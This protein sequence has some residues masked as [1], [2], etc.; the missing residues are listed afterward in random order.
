MYLVHTEFQAPAGA[1]AQALEALRQREAAAAKLLQETGALLS[2][3]REPGTTRTWGVWAA[4]SEAELRADLE[5]L[6]CYP[7]M[8]VEV[9]QIST[10]PNSLH[11][12]P[13]AGQAR[14]NERC[15][16]GAQSTHAPTSVVPAPL[17]PHCEVDDR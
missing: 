4:E 1:T 3:W 11:T 2:L 16:P 12:E 10:H 13:R 15:A 7:Y 17:Q 6:P 9:R 14:I 8:V 5:A